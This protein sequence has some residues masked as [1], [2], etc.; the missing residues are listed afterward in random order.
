MLLLANPM[1]RIECLVNNT[2]TPYLLTDFM[3]LIII[4]IISLDCEYLNDNELCNSVENQTKEM[5]I[6]NNDNLMGK[7]CVGNK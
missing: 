4:I 2:Q 5:M 3:K 1:F 6:K 7:L